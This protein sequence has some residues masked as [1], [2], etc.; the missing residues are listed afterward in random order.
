M[1]EKR[2]GKLVLEAP[3]GFEYSIKEGTEGEV[4]LKLVSKGEESSKKSDGWDGV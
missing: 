3:E 4:I 2:Y 1:N